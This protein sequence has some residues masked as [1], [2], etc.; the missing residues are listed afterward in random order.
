MTIL[1]LINI[2]S[3]YVLENKLE[4]VA[5]IS[6]IVGVWLAKKEN[7]LVY[8]IGSISVCIWI[9][10]LWIGAVYGQSTINLFFLVMNLYGWYN[11]SR[12]DIENQNQ[13]IVTSN[14]KNQNLLVVTVSI[15]LSFAIYFSLLPFQDPSELFIY[16]A[17]EAFITA[18]NFVAMWLMAWKRVENW[19]LWII[20]D[21]LCIPLYI[22]QEY[23]VSVV[24]FSVFIIIA[25]LGY[26]E[27]KNKLNKV[28]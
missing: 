15:A 14:S 16:I 25:Y 27:W 2:V 18:L 3:A 1:E 21:V 8:P 6:G 11:W 22:H 7:I 23:Y 4:M 17:L 13:V 12:K 26:V 5:V 24:Q 28:E 9:Y 19:I 10:L 20:G